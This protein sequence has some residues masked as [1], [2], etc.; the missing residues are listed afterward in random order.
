M[1]LIRG[2]L[3]A[4]R[5][6]TQHDLNK[7]SHEDQRNTLIVEMVAHSNQSVGD[8]Q[9]LN[10]AALAGVG[11]VMVFLREAKIRDDAT[12]KTMSADDQRNTLIVEIDGQTHL[13]PRL[14]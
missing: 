14:Q 4:G 1:S 11:A 5:F 13:G 8:Y 7:M 2:V 12:L 3:L 10:D 6:R 9:S